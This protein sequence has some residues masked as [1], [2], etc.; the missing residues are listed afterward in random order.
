MNSYFLRK[1]RLLGIAAGSLLTITSWSFAANTGRIVGTVTD[2]TSSE[3]LPGANVVI[4]GTAFGSS[5]NLNGEYAINAVPPGNYTVSVTFI[6]YEVTERPLRVEPDELVVLNVAMLGT[7]LEGETV[8]ISA[9]REGQI[10]AI[11]AQLTADALVNVVSSEKI[12]EVPDANTAESLARLPGVSLQ[13]D[14]GEGSQVVVR[15]LSPKYSKVTIDGIEMATTS[16]LSGGNIYEDNNTETRSTNL[17]AVAQ[18]NL[19]GIAL[20]KAP[21]ADMDGDAIGGTV[22]LQTA[23]AGDRPERIVRG[24]GSYNSLEADYEQYDIFGKI[25]QRFLDGKLGLQFSVNAEQR[26]RSTDQFSAGYDVIEAQR[27]TVTGIA[28]VKVTSSTVEDRLETRK[29]TGGSLILDLNVGDGN[30]TVTNFY[31]KTTRDIASRT[32][33]IS[34]S[35][36]GTLNISVTDRTLEQLSNTLRGEHRLFGMD[37]SWLGARSYSKSQIP[38]QHD[39]DFTDNVSGLDLRETVIGRDTSGIAWFNQIPGF[40]DAL[41]LN[42]AHPVEDFVDEENLIGRIDLSRDFSIDQNLAGNVKVGGKIKNVNRKRARVRGQLWAYLYPPWTNM[43]SNNFLDESYKPHNFLDGDTELGTVLDVQANRPFFETYRDYS[44]PAG[45]SRNAL[46]SGNNDYELD[47][48]I[49]AGYAMAKLNY[50]QLLTFIPGIRYEAVDNKYVADTYIQLSDGPE[51]KEGSHFLVF[52]DTTS[53]A[54]YHD[55]LP[56][57]HLKV[58]PLD[59]FDLRL[60]VTRTIARPDYNRV[61]PYQFLSTLP[62]ATARIGNSGLKPTRAWNYDAYASFYDS[63]WGLF[64]V[65]AFYKRLEGI[66][67]IYNAPPLDRA[68]ADSLAPIL[69]LDF[70]QLDTQ[71]GVRDL[72]YNH[73]LSMPVNLEDEGIVKGVEFEV[74]TNLRNWPVPR[75]LKGVVLGFNYSIIHSETQV[76]DVLVQIT[77]IPTPPFVVINRYTASRKIP[78]PG[79]ADRLGNVTLGYDI[80]GFSARLSVFHQSES[81]DNPNTLKED[82]RYNDAFTRWDLSLRQ[83]LTSRLDAY[84]NVVN[85]TDTRDRAYVDR[86]DRPTRLSSF[87]RTMDLGL[88]VRL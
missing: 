25:S 73:G 82:D 56:M 71:Y 76:R 14:G 74:Q 15:G 65:G 18:E 29:R 64:T 52:E 88:Q 32:Q 67:I 5:T 62:E 10:A 79:Q 24:Y 3:V 36:R 59:W 55:W 58:K 34:T 8:V 44:D 20:Y 77:Q 9:Q 61:I 38:F 81:L 46:Y 16:E 83:R 47:E 60:S 80:R 19:K 30:I 40:Y 70:N 31:S 84:F 78:V 66:H 69:G 2:S 75:L 11:N 1:A 13:R 42:T 41:Q 54:S 26:N 33:Q 72:F 28:P 50:R 53:T 12:L 87:G 68:R 7:Y 17:S 57:V 21:T 35:G 85:L 22:N 27:D 51:P 39:L 63:F 48:N 45:Y 49:Y 6:G 86:N 43:T 37:L 23:R 4:D